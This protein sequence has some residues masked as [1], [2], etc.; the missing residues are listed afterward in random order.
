MTVLPGVEQP[1]LRALVWIVYYV[2]CSETGVLYIRKDRHDVNNKKGENSRKLNFHVLLLQY[3]PLQFRS[4]SSRAF[5]L[6]LQRNYV[7]IVSSISTATRD[8]R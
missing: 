1:C 3:D 2:G 6:R 5:E 8:K 7:C 4:I